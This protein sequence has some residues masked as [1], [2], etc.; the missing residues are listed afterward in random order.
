MAT[1]SA[2]LRAVCCPCLCNGN[3]LNPHKLRLKLRLSI[4]KKHGYDF[5]KVAIELIERP[6]LGVCPKNQGKTDEQSRSGTTLYYR[7]RINPHTQPK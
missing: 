4:F 1:T 7:R 2:G 6:P 3:V 5:L